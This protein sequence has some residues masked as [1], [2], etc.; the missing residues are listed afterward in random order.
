MNYEDYNSYD[1][2]RLQMVVRQI[3]DRGIKNSAVLK[4]ME[5]VPRHEF[6]PEGYQ[7]DSYVD[8]PLPIG[9]DQTISQPYIVAFMTEI[10][11]LT[12]NDVVLEIGTGSGYQSA[13]L[14][15]L[16]KD[17]YTIEIIEK[18]GLRAKKILESL[19]CDNVHMK[20]GDGYNGWVRESA[21]DA[22]IVTAAPDHVPE[23][24]LGQLKNG[25]KMI[26][27][28]GK[29]NYDQVLRLITKDDKGNVESKNVL[30]VRFVPLT[31]LKVS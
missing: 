5:T 6:V 29:V 23:G 13:V 19:G 27:P 24:L 30:A 21:Y 9:F 31:R 28:T 17:V 25:G 14:S 10:L 15:L 26:I 18:L 12:P 7:C 22:I 4:A 16:V 11:S 1:S 3:K 20:I 8:G 2:E